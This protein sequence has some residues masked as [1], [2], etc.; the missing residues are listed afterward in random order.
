M[1]NSYELINKRITTTEKLIIAYLIFMTFQYIVEFYFREGSIVANLIFRFMVLASMIT[2]AVLLLSLKSKINPYRIYFLWVFIIIL[3]LTIVY[4]IFGEGRHLSNIGIYFGMLT[5]FFVSNVDIRILSIAFK[6]IA[7]VGLIVFIYIFVFFEI[8][9]SVALRRGYTWTETFFFVSFYWA[10][11]PLVVF[12]FLKDKYIKLSLIYWGASVIL[13][14]MFIKRAIIVDSIL[15]VAV[16]MLIIAFKNS[17]KF[18]L[19]IKYLLY[20]TLTLTTLFIVFGDSVKSLWDE[21]LLRFQETGENISSFD[22]FVESINYF[23]TVEVTELLIGKGFLGT[24]VG[25]GTESDA[26]H[27]GWSN[28]ILKGGLLLFIAVIIPYFKM[29]ILLPKIKYLPIQVQFS[30][31]I[32]LIYIVK[33][34]YSNLHTFLPEMLIFFYCLFSV[35]DHKKT[36]QLK[37]T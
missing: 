8:D 12:S 7:I 20:I 5:A 34:T 26:L 17:N 22:R 37:H 6:R 1:K 13:N 21:V 15:L 10:V 3:I 28:F 14:L 2:P 32:M 31:C 24:H 9:I 16:I 29:F 19:V 18:K 23:G 30:I 35:M 11:I 27:I 33:L 25:L 36:E 4:L